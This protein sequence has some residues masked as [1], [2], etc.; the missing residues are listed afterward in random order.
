MFSQ[1]SLSSHRAGHAWQRV[2]VAGVMHKEGVHGRGHV[3]QGACMD[4]GMCGGGR[5]AVCAGEMATETGGTHPTG[6]H[7][8]I[9][10]NFPRL[11]IQCTYSHCT[12]FCN[13]CNELVRQY[14]Y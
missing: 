7:S 5:G 12:S 11:C 3:W 10:L 9:K 13:S 8:C 14:K 2:C 1:V 4:W 6:M